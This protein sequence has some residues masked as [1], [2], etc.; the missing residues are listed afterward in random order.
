MSE[1]TTLYRGHPVYYDG[2][3][4]RYESTGEIFDRD[5]VCCVLCHKPPTPEGY[6]AC[7][8]YI[9]DCFSACCGHGIE[10]GYV[11]MNGYQSPN[12]NILKLEIE[13]ERS[14]MYLI[15]VRATILSI[16]GWLLGFK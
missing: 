3:N 10:R 8:G 13:F 7:L 16:V 5:S 9:P 14:D 11:I 4:F 1:S 6:D 2:D 12:E 15:Q